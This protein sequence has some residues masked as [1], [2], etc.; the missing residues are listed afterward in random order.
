M[1]RKL[2]PHSIYSNAANQHKNY[3][4]DII[5]N[6]GQY[7]EP[8]KFNQDLSLFFHLAVKIYKVK[9]VFD[10]AQDLIFHLRQ[11]LIRYHEAFKFN[12][13]LSKI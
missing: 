3:D 1:S 12:G 8:S 6:N 2:R 11:H 7:Y 10:I 9:H 13:V 5:N 4:H